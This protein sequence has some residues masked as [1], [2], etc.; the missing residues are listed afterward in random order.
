MDVFSD[1]AVPGR[2]LFVAADEA[3][4]CP[5]IEV[6]TTAQGRSVKLVPGTQG[7]AEPGT[8][9]IV[10]F[11]SMDALPAVRAAQHV[12]DL[13]R[14]YGGLTVRGVGIVEK[15]PSAPRAEAFARWQGLALRLLYDDLSALKKMSRQMDVEIK[16]ALPSIFIIDR[17]G[18]LRFH[19]GG[20]RFWAELKQS[21]KSRYEIINE[22]AAEGQKIEDYLRLILAE[23]WEI[24]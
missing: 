18:R 11:W 19:R 5:T 7:Y 1:E 10:V 14:K 4:K 20:F 6:S 23:R 3:K 16:T 24:P 8:V 22:S 12:S 9:T 13:V 2:T 15:T 17:G 21:E